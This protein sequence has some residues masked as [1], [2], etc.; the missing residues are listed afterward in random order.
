[1]RSRSGSSPNAWAAD[2]HALAPLI[3]LHGADHVVLLEGSEIAHKHRKLWIVNGLHVVMA[4]IARR[5]GVDRLP[6]R[7]EPLDAFRASIK[8][9]MLAILQAVESEY[10][11][12]TDE[13]FADERVRAFCEAPDSASRVLTDRYLRADLRPYMERIRSRVGAAA[14]VAYEHGID[15]EP[16]LWAF[17]EVA[18]AIHESD[19]FLDVTEPDPERP[20]R[21][22][23]CP[24][25]PLIDAEVDAEAVSIFADALAGWAPT[26]AASLL[27]RRV[28]SSLATWRE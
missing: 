12:A 21:L 25:P 5:C 6:L 16:F 26:P 15:I 18:D 24:D 11:L 10:G 19:S 28:D 4:T 8:P 23:P 7:D 2:G 3:G 27:I 1:M 17:A 13:Q 22:R 20:W 14:M 9:L